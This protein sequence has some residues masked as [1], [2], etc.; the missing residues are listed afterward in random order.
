[1]PID[2][3]FDREAVSLNNPPLTPSVLPQ[4]T[5]FDANNPPWG[6]GGAL[7]VWFLSLLLLAIVPLILLI[8]YAHYRGLSLTDPNFLLTFAQFAV[9]DKTA[10]V[11]QVV[12]ILP[13]HLLTFG[14][15]WALVTRFG[16]Y[17]FLK[18]IGWEWPSPTWRWLSVLLGVVFFGMAVVLAK[19]VGA[20]KPTQLEQ[21]VN[22]SLTA[23]YAIAF[24]AVF[25]APFV[26]EFVYRGVL[27][28]AL[29]RLT[30]PI[31][32]GIAT[33]ALFTL[34]HVPQY[35]PNIG[36]ISSVALLTVALTVVRAKSGRLL[37]C[38]VIHFVFNGIMSLIL[39]IEPY[40]PITE[41]VPDPAPTLVLLLRLGF[42]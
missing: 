13:T 24:L 14:L 35:W 32:A 15:V 11:L 28:A 19:L 41:S 27:F 18:S 30:G 16:K 4:Q 23:R 21:I 37:P 2:N 31:V 42:F 1:M 38:V 12:S 5:Q 25:T 36:V 40:L 9:T 3:Q 20:D 10:I 39:L 29:Q 8:P 26:E 17:S 33:L 34:I 7:L 6:F 22:S